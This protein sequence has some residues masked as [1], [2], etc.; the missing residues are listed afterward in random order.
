MHYEHIIIFNNRSLI[1]NLTDNNV[2]SVQYISFNIGYEK[3]Y[4]HTLFIFSIITIINFITLIA[5][6]QLFYF[7]PINSR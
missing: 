7:G 5:T 2:K 6:E 3:Q 1:F 4:N